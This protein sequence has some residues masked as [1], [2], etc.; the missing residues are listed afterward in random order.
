MQLVI[1]KA[2]NKHF[3]NQK[4][5]FDVL[6]NVENR[7]S[8]KGSFRSVAIN[9]QNVIADHDDVSSL[10]QASIKYRLLPVPSSA[11]SPS[12]PTTRIE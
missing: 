5:I 1:K 10:Q 12:R 4:P 3:F 7:I 6:L 9:G 2:M 11:E 8:H